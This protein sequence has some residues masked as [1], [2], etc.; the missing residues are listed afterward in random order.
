MKVIL[1]IITGG[2]QMP[3]F[4]SNILDEILTPV[5]LE[6]VRKKFHFEK[7]HMVEIQTVAMRMIPLIQTEAFWERK[8]FLMPDRTNESNN[9]Y[10]SVFMS[11]GKGIDYLQERYEEGEFLLKSYILEVLANEILLR[12]YDAYNQYIKK[13]TNWH[14][15]RYY[16]LGSEAAFPLDILPSLLKE[17]SLQITC[18]SA[19]YM[20][21]NKSVVFI[22]E[23][24]QDE[25]RYCGSICFDC[26]NKN[27]PNK[28]EDA[29]SICSGPMPGSIKKQIKIKKDMSM[30]YGYSRIFG[31]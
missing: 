17:C 8:E 23:L 28:I 11:L 25:K 7:T 19:F 13:E 12:G 20:S 9:I 4:F 6:R 2:S 3:A 10:E 30:L 18:N 26:K 16:F 1:F 14:V 5:F 15:A 27:C 31:I 21:P 24:T 22:S 29:Y